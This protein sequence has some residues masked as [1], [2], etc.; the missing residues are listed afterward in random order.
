MLESEALYLAFIAIG[1]DWE[2]P[3][4]IIPDVETCVRALYGDNDYVALV[5]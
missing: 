4:G 5:A 3:N 1:R 2:V